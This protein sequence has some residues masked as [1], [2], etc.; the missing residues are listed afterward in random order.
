M[1]GGKERQEGV[2]EGDPAPPASLICTFGERT[3]LKH[4]MEQSDMKNQPSPW[5]AKKE[6]ATFRGSSLPAQVLL[7]GVTARN[8]GS[9]WEGRVHPCSNYHEYLGSISATNCYSE[10]S[11]ERW[12]LQE[13]DSP[14]ENI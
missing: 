12:C 3:V 8:Q 11:P 4:E 10:Q 6:A 5:K 13:Q 1:Q 14:L 2:A 7:L 9:L